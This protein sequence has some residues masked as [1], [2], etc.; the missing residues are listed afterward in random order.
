MRKKLEKGLVTMGKFRGSQT[1]VQING[2]DVCDIPIADDQ[3]SELERHM[4]RNWF[5]GIKGTK[6]FP[7]AFNNMQHMHDRIQAWNFPDEVKDEALRH[8]SLLV[9][10]LSAKQGPRLLRSEDHGRFDP[11][12]AA[13]VL[14]GIRQGKSIQEL[15][16]FVRVERLNATPP[17]IGIM[18]SGNWS[19]FWNNP[20]NISMYAMLGLAIAWACEAVGARCIVS[21]GRAVDESFDKRKCDYFVNF[22]DW[23]KVIPLR[24]YAMAFH[25]E[26]YRV[27]ENF[28]MYAHPDHRKIYYAKGENPDRF[29]EYNI[30]ECARQHHHGVAWLREV[31]KCDTVISIGDFADAATADVVIPNTHISIPDAI[32]AIANRMY[33]Q[34]YG[35]AA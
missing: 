24:G 18:A 29:S 13:R 21:L 19:N 15:R 31:H 14:A 9:D 16:P 20:E 11:R 6:F 12:A 8:A 1:W 30:N 7:G 25:P 17:T 27:G 34:R 33:K 32:R 28:F 3:W 23:S 22:Y 5:H 10:T 2:A 35:A 4:D 26:I